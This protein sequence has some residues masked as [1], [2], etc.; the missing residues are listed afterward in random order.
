[1]ILPNQK[2]TD[3]MKIE[4]IVQLNA[5]MQRL[6]NLRNRIIGGVAAIN[7][8]N[9]SQSVS[10]IPTPSFINLIERNIDV[11]A[12]GIEVRS[13]KPTRIWLGENRDNPLF[14]FDDVNRWV[15][16]LDLISK[17]LEEMQ[18]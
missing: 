15:E 18:F 2:P 13:M 14:S 17:K 9:V 10:T 6:A 4:Y 8:P 3:F 16:S 7:L 11:L 1:M 12:A 5:E